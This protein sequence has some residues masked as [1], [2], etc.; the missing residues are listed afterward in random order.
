MSSAPATM[1]ASPALVKAAEELARVALSESTSNSLSASKETV[2]ELRHLHGIAA[3]IKTATAAAA[4]AEAA[5]L[6]AILKQLRDMEANAAA[7]DLKQQTAARLQRL[8]WAITN[9]EHGSFEYYVQEPAANPYNHYGHQQQPVS[10]QST[11]KVQNILLNAITGYGTRIG[12]KNFSKS[13]AKKGQTYDSK[14]DLESVTAFHA[15]LCEHIFNL[16][17]E[18]PV[19]SADDEG[20]FSIQ[21]NAV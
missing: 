5:A 17:S 18:L 2:V 7:R 16:T 20:N 14:V 4:A 15:A 3:T 6:A 9:A 12:Q 11:A 10:T 21:F 8:Q 13:V 1:Q 19:V